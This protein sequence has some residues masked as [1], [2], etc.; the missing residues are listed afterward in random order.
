MHISKAVLEKVGAAVHRWHLGS[1]CEKFGIDKV[2]GRMDTHGWTDGKSAYTLSP[3]IQ[4]GGDK[5]NPSGL[6][7][8]LQCTIELWATRSNMRAVLALQ[9]SL[10][11]YTPHS[12]H[13][14]SHITSYKILKINKAKNKQTKSALQRVHFLYA[15]L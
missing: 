14:L 11:E 1:V 13:N 12:T 5:Y 3:G 2:N 15:K 9:L 8:L 4:P 7:L 10:P 6:W